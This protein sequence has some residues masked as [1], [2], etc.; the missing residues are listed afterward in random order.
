MLDGWWYVPPS[1][2][3]AEGGPV[4]AGASNTHAITAHAPSNATTT[5]AA[6]S[7]VSP[8]DVALSTWSLPSLPPYAAATEQAT[9]PPG[10][11]LPLSHTK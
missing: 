6:A 9:S 2:D 8:P 10:E 3:G 5:T 11:T 4:R 1:P 7:T